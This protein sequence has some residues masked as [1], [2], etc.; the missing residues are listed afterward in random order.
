MVTVAGIYWFLISR[1]F[2]RWCALALA[3]LAPLVVL[4]LFIQAGLLLEVLIAVG[5]VFVAVVCARAA[6]REPREGS[7]MTE[8]PAPA[9]QHPFLVMNPRSGGGK[10]V[11]FDLQRKAEELGAEVALLE[12]PG[13]WM[14]MRWPGRRWNAEPTCSASPAGT[15]PRRWWPASRPNTT[16]PSW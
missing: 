6:L 14:S 12:G 2:L 11:K 8:Y 1:G 13:R 3:V 15:G 5:L 9:W 16:C 4:F 10:V 7:K